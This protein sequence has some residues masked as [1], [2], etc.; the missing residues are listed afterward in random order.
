MDYYDSGYDGITVKP[1]FSGLSDKRTLLSWDTFVWHGF[2][3]NCKFPV[4][5]GHLL[6]ADSGQA[7]HRIFHPLPSVRGQFA[8]CEYPLIVNFTELM[9]IL[10]T[11]RGTRHAVQHE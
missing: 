11:K 8:S 5:R 4:I 6:N 9:Q 1:A 10:L 3:F 7:N 2:V